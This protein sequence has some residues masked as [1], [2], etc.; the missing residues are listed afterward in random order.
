MKNNYKINIIHNIETSFVI[1]VLDKTVDAVMDVVFHN[2]EFYQQNGVEVLLICNDE[3][4]IELKISPIIEQYPLVNWV[5]VFCENKELDSIA[6]INTAI[7]YVSKK[8]VFISI[9]NI[10]FEN[11]IPYIVRHLMHYYDHSYIIVEDKNAQHNKTPIGILC[12]IEDLKQINKFKFH[13][14]SHFLIDLCYKLDKIGVN[15]LICNDTKYKLHKS[16]ANKTSIEIADLNFPATLNPGVKLY[17]WQSNEH[18]KQSFFRYIEDFEQ[19]HIKDDA[20]H[21]KYKKI[22]LCQSYNESDLIVGFL[23]NMAQYFDG[24]ILLDDGSSDDTYTKAMHDKLIFKCQK[25]HTEFNDLQNRNTLLDIASFFNSEWFCFMDIDERID[26]R[27]VDFFEHIDKVDVDNIGFIFIHLWDS[28]ETYNTKMKDCIYKG[29][30]NRWRMFRNTG[31]A[32][33]VTLT[34]KLHFPAVPLTDSKIVVPVLIHHYGNLTKKRR[35]DKFDF[36][37]VE[38]T[39]KDLS[40]YDDLLETIGLDEL[41][42]VKK[43]SYRKIKQFCNIINRRH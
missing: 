35:Q 19:Y 4:T 7:K 36:Y 21:N 18:K 12:D 32:N 27:Y 9:P 17:N 37:K 14:D 39:F 22:I 28:T 5:V 3:K 23:D 38:D 34:K 26:P 16:I 13:T 31:R 8:N 15:K 1:P 33:L 20:F 29:L 24:I 11:N 10:L 30:F 2:L 6:L 40:S 25:K 42:S 41:L 43:I